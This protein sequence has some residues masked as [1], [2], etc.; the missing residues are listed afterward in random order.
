MAG[1]VDK[2][3]AG[4]MFYFCVKN[5]EIEKKGII[6]KI[7]PI[8]G[9]PIDKTRPM[10]SYEEL[11]RS[12]QQEKKE[13]DKAEKDSE[14]VGSANQSSPETEVPS[15]TDE[16]L[17]G[18]RPEAGESQASDY[19]LEEGERR[20]DKAGTGLSGY[21]AVGLSGEKRRLSERIGSAGYTTVGSSEKTGKRTGR[22]EAASTDY[23]AVGGVEKDRGA[24]ANYSNVSRMDSFHSPVQAEA[25]ISSAN[26][27][28][29]ILDYFGSKL[30]IPVEGA[31]IGR[32]GL[33]K[34][35]FDGNLMIS[36][37]HVF[38]RPDQK[39]GRLRIEMDKSLNGVFYSGPGGEKIR[40]A[41][42]RMMEV[43][44][45]LWIYNIPLVIGNLGR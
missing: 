26:P 32:E 29:F 11:Q 7:C 14:K 30:Q 22:T 41:G 9:S 39:T 40:L 15:K 34:E 3:N 6:N 42:A 33:G 28:G 13:Q 36:R 16:V 23:V 37:R 21:T 8:C 12:K 5:H 35:W 25:A 38:V 31:W 18:S 43:G 1:I 19:T 24:S 27:S 17:P 10:V 45:I 4:R 44:D 20:P 2:S